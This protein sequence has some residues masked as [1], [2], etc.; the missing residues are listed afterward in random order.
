[1]F[2]VHFVT[3]DGGSSMFRE[4]S[5]LF[6][7]LWAGWGTWCSLWLRARGEV[8]VVGLLAGIAWCPL[9]PGFRGVHYPWD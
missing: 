6:L 1:M 4:H 5:S 8:D 2:A 7:G 3:P 9:R